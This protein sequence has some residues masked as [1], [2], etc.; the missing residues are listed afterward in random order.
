M[1]PGSA[2][3][4]DFVEISNVI[5]CFY[6]EE[7]EADFEN[8]SHILNFSDSEDFISDAIYYRI[9]RVLECSITDTSKS[10]V[11]RMATIVN[12]ESNV[13]HKFELGSKEKLDKVKSAKGSHPSQTRPSRPNLS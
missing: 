13:G 2:Y 9:D 10:R 11:T 1:G 7:A 3:L 5:N 6:T 12:A 4:V 8:L